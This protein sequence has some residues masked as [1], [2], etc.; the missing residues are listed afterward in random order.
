MISLTF[1]LASITV[2]VTIE[3][4]VEMLQKILPED[5]LDFS[6]SEL[7]SVHLEWSTANTSEMAMT[8][9]KKDRF[10]EKLNS[11]KSELIC[12]P[13]F[14][15]SKPLTVSFLGLYERWN[16]VKKIPAAISQMKDQVKEIIVSISVE[17][18]QAS[19]KNS[20]VAFETVFWPEEK[21]LKNK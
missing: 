10:P 6:T 11:L 2:T 17:I 4:Y 16:Q 13:R 20:A 9:L 14:T 19:S 18:L 21:C 7:V 8:W 1:S 5:S 12:P 3:T 15:R